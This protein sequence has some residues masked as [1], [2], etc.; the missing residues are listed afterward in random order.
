MEFSLEHVDWGIRSPLSGTSLPQPDCGPQ[1]ESLVPPPDGHD[2]TGEVDP[3]IHGSN[4][5]VKISVQ[6]TTPLDSQIFNTTAQ[7]AEFPFNQ[8]MNSGNPLGIGMF[9]LAHVNST[10]VTQTLARLGPV[11][12][13]RWPEEQCLGLIPYT[14]ALQVEF[15]HFN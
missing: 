7:L 12:N 5:A 9:C 8:D 4:G 13:R 2:T 15:R 11:L 1:I 3:A 10:N 6:D 14:G